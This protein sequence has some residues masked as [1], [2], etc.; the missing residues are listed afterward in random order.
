MIELSGFVFL[1]I[2]LFLICNPFASLPLFIAATEGHE[3]SDVKQYAN[4]AVIV[5]GILL[6]IFVLIGEPMMDIFNIT[7]ESFQVAG[8]VILLMMSIEIIFSLKLS[9]ME[10][11]DAAWVIIATPVLTG[12]GVITSAILFSAQYGHLPVLIAGAIS[13]LSIWVI[14][15]NST[16]VMR[17]AGE[18][19][20]GIASRVIGLIIAAMA[21]EYMFTGASSWFSIYG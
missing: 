12:P 17:F 8:G 21:I 13:L 9:K 3:E 16:T 2:S 7:M 20:I 6:F 11:G 1:I 4:K 19:S 18:Q 15:R 14:L 5:A 10:K